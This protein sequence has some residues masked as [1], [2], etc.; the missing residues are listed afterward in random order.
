MIFTTILSIIMIS[1]VVALCAFPKLSDKISNKVQLI[2]GFILLVLWI[3]AVCIESSFT[4]L[5]I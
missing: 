1:Y 3:I 2:S 4:N 5:S